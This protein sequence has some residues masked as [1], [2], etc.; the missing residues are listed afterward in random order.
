[1][2]RVVLIREYPDRM[3]PIPKSDRCVDDQTFGTADS[4]VWVEDR[5]TDHSEK[6][7]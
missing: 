2:L 4:E 1:M 5:D 3:S 6:W 7:W